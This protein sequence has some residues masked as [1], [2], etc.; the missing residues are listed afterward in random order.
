MYKIKTKKTMIYS[1]V[2]VFILVAL[3]QI[4]KL[5]ASLFL[6]GRGPLKVIKGVFELQYLE[7]DSAAF[8]LDPVS[9][10]HRV[11]HFTYFDAHPNAFL[12][13]KM[14]FFIV[15]TIAV[16]TILMVLYRRIPEERHF[17]PMNLIAIGIFAGAIGNLIDRICHQYVIDFFYFSLIDFPV[18]NVAD[19]YVTVSAI[20]L[21]IF[22]LF[23]Y[24]E[25]D[26]ECLFPPRKE[27]KNE[28]CRKKYLK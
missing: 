11:F 13:C 14:V 28:T 20:A 5:L 16:L 1:A 6:K 7:N 27:R 24:K 21:V 19:I 15:L 3:D 22:V 4:T 25:K 2:L 9:I 23:F 26:F 12:M 10:L 17:L 18:F 8:S